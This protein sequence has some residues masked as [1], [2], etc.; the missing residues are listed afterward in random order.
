MIVSRQSERGRKMNATDRPE[1]TADPTTRTVTHRSG[2]VFKFYDYQNESDWLNKSIWPDEPPVKALLK[3]NYS[4]K[5][6]AIALGAARFAKVHMP[7]R[8]ADA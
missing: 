7:Y 4:E 2:V 1:F 3:R 6:R 8:R 5:D